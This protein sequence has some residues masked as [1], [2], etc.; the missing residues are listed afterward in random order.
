MKTRKMTILTGGGGQE[1]NINK[2]A[3][4]N[5]PIHSFSVNPEILKINKGIRDGDDLKVYI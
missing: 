1:N 3:A 4:D 2:P 5:K